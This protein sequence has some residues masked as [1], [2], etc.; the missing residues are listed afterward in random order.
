MDALFDSLGGIFGM[1]GEALKGLVAG[2]LS[3]QDLLIIGLWL[4]AVTV[5]VLTISYNFV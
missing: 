5:F 3:P 1:Q 2:S 4:L